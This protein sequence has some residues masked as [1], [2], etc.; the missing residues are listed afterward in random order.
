MTFL[1]N[2]DNYEWPGGF[3]FTAPV[4]IAISSYSLVQSAENWF[5][6]GKYLDLK[7]VRKCCGLEFCTPIGFNYLQG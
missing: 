4:L 3:L 2:K 7:E 1:L 6:L 5:K